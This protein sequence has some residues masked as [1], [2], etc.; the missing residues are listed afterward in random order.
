MDTQDYIDRARGA[1]HEGELDLAEQ[2]LNLILESSPDH[3][4][5]LEG[6]KEIRVTRVRKGWSRPLQILVEGWSRFLMA[7]GSYRA[8]VGPLELLHRSN[9][10]RFPAAVAYAHCCDKL[11]RRTEALAVYKAAIS[12]RPNHLPSL[13]RAAHL[14]EKEDRLDEAIEYL[15]RLSLLLPE[16]DQIAHR[17]RDLLARQYARTGVPE[18]L[19]ERRAEMEKELREMPGSPEF[20]RRLGN[21]EDLCRQRPDDI[22]LRLDL[23]A[24]LREGGLLDRANAQLAPIID[25]NP[26]HFEARLEQARL[27]RVE[28]EL[29]IAT[30]LFETLLAERPEDED[31]RGAYLDSRLALLQQQ[32]KESS[33]DSELQRSLTEAQ[34]QRD[35][36]RISILKKHLREHPDDH[37]GRLELGQ[38]LLLSKE[39]DEA[40]AVLQRLLHEPSY[41]GQAFTVLGT[42]FR[43]RGQ[44]DLAAEQYRK[45][46][47]FFKDRGYSHI[48]S[49]ELKEA[50]YFLGLCL[51]KQGK[52][53]AAREAYTHVYTTDIN[54]RDIRD[55]Y[56]QTY[57]SSSQD[58]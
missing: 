52:F 2:Y 14:A 46:I 48:P 37:E 31:L 51:E 30:N 32:V 56:E 5:A 1:I 12:L 39:D 45:A 18:K 29:R 33:S 53:E 44:L 40:I 7:L 27:W 22:Q 54:Y 42:C 57:R 24:H 23:V 28:N 21:L 16:D 10:G 25:E 20:T 34:Q 36:H 38:L 6:L 26:N 15:K 3:P 43:E 4:T 50:Y 17:M 11:D 35:L 8:A 13:R 58:S 19:T 49:E 41:A 55:R 47:S 9:P